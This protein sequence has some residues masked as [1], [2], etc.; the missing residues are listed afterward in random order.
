MS[1]FIFFAI[2]KDTNPQKKA[3]KNDTILKI[4]LGKNGLNK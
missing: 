4:T 2:I 3:N 1:G